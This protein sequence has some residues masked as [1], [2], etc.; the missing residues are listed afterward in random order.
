MGEEGVL[1]IDETSYAI[2]PHFTQ[3]EPIR[4]IVTREPG[5]RGWAGMGRAG[6][7]G[8]DIRRRW[9]WRAGLGWWGGP[10]GRGAASRTVRSGGCGGAAANGA[11]AIT[12]ATAFNCTLFFLHPPP[13]CCVASPICSG[14]CSLYL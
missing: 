1:G 4:S 3:T 12:L 2:L 13:T 7:G 6:L 9:T 11:C 10:I 8:V 14:H 5:G